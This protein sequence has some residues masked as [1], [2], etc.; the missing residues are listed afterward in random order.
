MTRS[1]FVFVA[2]EA[3]ISPA[4][5]ELQLV[6]KHQNGPV[7]QHSRREA[8]NNYV[9]PTELDEVEHC[10]VEFDCVDL[11]HSVNEGIF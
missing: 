11:N 9:L 3:A 4:S 7:T 5:V 1:K 10:S 8:S 6:V 2:S